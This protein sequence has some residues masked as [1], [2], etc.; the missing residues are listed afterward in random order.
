[1]QKKQTGRTTGPPVI[2]PAYLLTALV[3]V[4]KK[5]RH[6]VKFAEHHGNVLML[7][8]AQ[9]S[10]GIVNNALMDTDANPYRQNQEYAA[11]QT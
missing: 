11:M 2:Y 5:K 10:R 4:V 7:N 6:Q 3:E 8:C 9:T 1:M